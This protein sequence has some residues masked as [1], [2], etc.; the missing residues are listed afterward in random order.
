MNYYLTISGI[1]AIL[2]T[3]GHLTIGSTAFL[4]HMLAAEFD[5]VS[6]RTMHCGFH[7][8]S[9]YFFTSAI[10]L[11]GL[12][13]GILSVD[14]NLYLVRFIGI[15]WAGFAAIQ[16]FIILTCKIERGFIRRFQWILFSSIAILGF[17]GT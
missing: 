12:G 15:N 17:L 10:V 4:R 9:A 8:V 7:Y 6:K 13:L 3:H 2:S 1:L 11:T 16:I 14:N 5:V